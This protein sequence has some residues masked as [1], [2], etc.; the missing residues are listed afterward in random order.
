MRVE[1]LNGKNIEERMQILV[2]AG[3]LS[4]FNGD[5]FELYDLREGKN[6]SN[7]NI[8]K[9]IIEMGHESIIE[10]DYLIFAIKDVSPIIEQIL[11]SQRLSSFTV[12]SRREVDFSK[13]GY[14]TPDFSYLKNGDEISDKYNEH[15]KYLFDEY[16]NI[17]DKG[18]KKEDAR[19]VLPYSYHSNLVMGIDGRTFERLILYCTTGKMS[20]LP[21]VREFGE[22]LLELAR[23]YAPYL[24]NKLNNLEYSYTDEVSF[25]D[26]K[27]STKYTLAE[28]PELLS[29][30]T[31]FNDGHSLSSID[32]TIMVSYIMNRYQISQSQALSMYE[33]LS[34]NEKEMLM[35]SICTSPNQRELEQVSFKYRIPISLAVLTH[36]TRHRMH[37]LLIPDFL[38][39]Y[40]LSKHIVPPA[41]RSKCLDTYE[42]VYDNNLKVYNEF[43]KAGVEEKD[44]V[45]FNLSGNMINVTTNMN[46]RTLQWVSRMRCCNKAQWEIRNIANEMVRLVKDKS[47][48]YAKYLGASCDV[49][50]MCPE[51]KECC[52]K[53]Y[54]LKKDIKEGE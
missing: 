24:D 17:V 7:I 9:N 14:Y 40:D 49:L 11:I 52:G 12:K 4:R 3:M 47:E 2:T 25:L 19:F 26:D 18:I 23:E 50:G 1:L 44:L 8:I 43:K 33:T 10:H 46:G 53:I 41:V 48:Y 27:I 28:K 5:V 30:H 20:K 16:S 15:M 34:K 38:P 22:K 29:V 31:D 36:L 45:Y 32:R 21:E 39:I 6:K 54:T 42:A 13:V 51:E 35:A 37:S